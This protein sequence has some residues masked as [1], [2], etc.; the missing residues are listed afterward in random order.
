MLWPIF[1]ASWFP[2]VLGLVQNS[3]DPRARLYCPFQSRLRRPWTARN[4]IRTQKMSGLGSLTFGVGWLHSAHM[5][6]ARESQ[7]PERE[8]RYAKRSNGKRLCE[9][10]DWCGDRVTSKQAAWTSIRCP[11]SGPSRLHSLLWKA[12]CFLATGAS[13]ILK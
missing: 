13:F 2:G 1:R 8:S 5:E 9:S 12:P 3:R 6:V 7:C 11:V 10:E 4:L